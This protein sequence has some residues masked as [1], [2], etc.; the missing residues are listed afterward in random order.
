[1]L[2][3]QLINFPGAPNLPIFVGMEKGFFESAGIA[4]V[5]NTT[6]SSTYQIENLVSGKYHIAGTAIDNVVAYT[7]GQGEILLKDEPDVFAF[8]GATQLELSF[9]VSPDIKDFHDLRGKTIALDALTTGFAFILYRMLDNA[10]VRRED[11]T[12]VPVGATPE[13]WRSVQ[14]GGHA[15]TLTIEPFTSSTK[16]AGYN[17]LETSAQ[18]VDSYQGGCFAAQRCLAANNRDAL[19]GFISGYLDGLE[20]TLDPA[21]REEGSQILLQNM[22]KINPKTI[23][24]VMDKLVSPK[25]GLTPKGQIDKKG[26]ETVLELRSYYSGHALGDISKYLDLEPYRSIIRDQY[27]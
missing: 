8:M 24:M 26:F 3:L 27:S 5:L 14:D 4:P 22:P 9:V 21:N 12:L 16:A 20:W 11:V 17:I 7:E 15:G 2:D 25:T 18:T 6:P 19:L 23:T 10:G 13:R 1:M